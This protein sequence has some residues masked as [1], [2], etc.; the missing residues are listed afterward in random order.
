[1]YL[2]PLL[3]WLLTLL[4]CFAQEIQNLNLSSLSKSLIH[5][6]TLPFHQNELICM[7]EYAD[8]LKTLRLDRCYVLIGE[9]IHSAEEKLWFLIMNQDYLTQTR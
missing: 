1:M 7:N 3:S 2:F 4:T 9:N 5:A 8:E 6:L